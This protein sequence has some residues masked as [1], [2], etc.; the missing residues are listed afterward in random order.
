MYS[1]NNKKRKIWKEEKERLLGMSLA[2]RR[3]E[4]TKDYIPLDTIPSLLDEMRKASND[5]E[6]QEVNSLCNKVSL[7]KGDITQLEV[8]VIVNAANA[9]LLG[10]G[11]VD[12]CIHRASGPYLYDE[13]RMLGGCATGQAKI[14]CGYKLPAKYVIHTVGPIAR[15]QLSDRH[16][17]DLASCY[18]SSLALAKEHNI[19]SIAFPCI[20]TGIYGFPNEPAANIALQTAKEWLKV[21]RNEM[22]RIIFCV[23]LEVDYKIYKKKLAEFFPKDGGDEDEKD[24]KDD[25]NEDNKMISEDTKGPDQNALSPPTKKSKAK[26]TDLQEGSTDA[27]VEDIKEPAQDSEDV[28]DPGSVSESTQEMKDP[29]SDSEH[30]EASAVKADVDMMEASQEENEDPDEKVIRTEADVSTDSQAPS[31][32][33]SKAEDPLSSPPE[34]KP[35]EQ[36]HDIQETNEFND[37]SKKLESENVTDDVHMCSQNIESPNDDDDGENNVAEEK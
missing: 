11:G 8:D 18:K 35:N 20:S 36:N 25:K 15:G 19:K 5:D 23:F 10:G 31:D 6:N 22:D 28:K 2:E 12:G 26:K 14:T 4:L 17:E 30:S 37:P 27:A 33:I 32:D 21:N 16:K 9:S 13:C 7:Y 24:D 34:D 29:G 1:S 3:K